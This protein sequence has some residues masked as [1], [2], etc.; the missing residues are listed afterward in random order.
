MTLVVIL[1]VRRGQLE[2]FRAFESQSAAIMARYGGTIERTVVIPPG[3]GSDMMREVHIVTFPGPAAFVSYREDA[4]L[5][6]AAPLREM[7]VVDTE[8]LVGEDGPDYQPLI[9]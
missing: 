1:T 5:Q 8:I 4:D 3:S 2:A 6:R 7:S 9:N